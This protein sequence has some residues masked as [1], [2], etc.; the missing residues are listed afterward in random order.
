[1]LYRSHTFEQKLHNWISRCLFLERGL[2]YIVLVVGHVSSMY[3]IYEGMAMSFAGFPEVESQLSI[4]KRRSGLCA[5]EDEVKQTVQML[6]GLMV[7]RHAT[8][9]R[10][11]LPGAHNPGV[12]PVS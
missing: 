2:T 7:V 10:P 1:M 5:A 9:R 6:C 3:M 12:L 4:E 11:F 8:T